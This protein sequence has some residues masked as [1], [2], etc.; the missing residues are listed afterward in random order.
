MFSGCCSI[1]PFNCLFEQ[2]Q[3][4]SQNR[5]KIIAT[6]CIRCEEFFVRFFQR[7]HFPMPARPS[8][9]S[10]ITSFH[11]RNEPYDIPIAEI[12]AGIRRRPSDRFKKRAINSYGHFGPPSTQCWHFDLQ[13]RHKSL[14]AGRAPVRAPCLNGERRGRLHTS[15]Q[16]RKFGLHP[17]PGKIHSLNFQTIPGQSF[18][19]STGDHKVDFSCRSSRFRSLHERNF[20]CDHDLVRWKTNDICKPS[21]NDMFLVESLGADNHRIPFRGID[22]AVR[23]WHITVQRAYPALF[24][25]WRFPFLKW[26]AGAFIRPVV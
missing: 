21:D 2:F 1:E 26:T 6:Y 19:T 18:L 15:F 13:L 16:F 14:C 5:F 12:V 24:T 20:S 25:A 11:F 17:G 10:V 23:T 4:I 9:L 8:I 22:H 7:K 3:F